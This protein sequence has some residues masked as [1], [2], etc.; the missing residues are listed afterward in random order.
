VVV[1]GSVRTRFLAAILVVV[2][3]SDAAA[4]WAMN[5]R[6]ATGA[7]REAENQARAQ[8][9]QV[10]ALFA[11]RAGTLAA[12][13]EAV[14]LYPAVIAA[15]AGGNNKPLLQWSGDVA[16]LQGTRVTVVDATGKVV[17]RGQAPQQVGD[18]LTGNL[19][20]L[21]IA[22]AGQKVS[23]VEPGDEL[24]LAI[25]GYA[26]TRQNGAVVGAVMIADPLDDQLA[27]KLIGAG[28]SI[29]ARVAAGGT[30]DAADSC[31]VLADASAA[32]CR[33]ALASPGGPPAATVSLT[34]PL[35]EVAQARDAAQRA[36][37]LT[38][39]VV[40]L[41]GIALAWLLARSL[42]RPLASLTAVAEDFGRGDYDRAVDVH[43]ADEIG[44]L[45]RE[46]EAMRQR[47]ASTTTALRNERDVLGAVLES[48]ED[49]IILVDWNGAPIVANG[50]WVELAGGNGLVALAEL[51]RVGGA[52]KTFA[53][54]TRAWL[55]DRDRVG[56]AD[57]EQFTPYRRF[58]CYSAP[59]RPREGA[60]LG[61]IIVLRDVTRESEAERM[62]GALVA[63]VSHELRSP[64]TAITGYT[65]TLLSGELWDDGTTRE[66]LDIVSQSARKL[67]SLV[68]NLLDA[69]KME[70]GVLSVEREPLRLERLARQVVAQRL[71]LVPGHKL[72]VDA[73]DDL[74]LVEADP[75]RVEQVIGNL[76]DNAIKYS[77]EGGSILVHVFSN[78]EGAVALSVSDQGIGIAPSHIE[79]LFQRFY[80]VDS[81]LART[82]KGVGLGLFICKGIVEAHG[83]R[84]EVTS[85]PG[86]GSTFTF[87]LP[88]LAAIDDAA[89]EVSDAP[90]KTG[91]GQ[92]LV[93]G[94]MG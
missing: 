80:R 79:Q 83:G 35:T 42:T 34:V 56:G 22:L 39:G 52:G 36:L 75:L 7:R 91:E 85:E 19:P 31:D 53:E 11:Q 58:R 45:A 76:V 70:A 48:T 73:E 38:G 69:A 4:A 57:F 61:R 59:V 27:Q 40:L 68:D 9:A 66:F 6:L 55:G 37:W 87:T 72:H 20:G 8:A 13:A 81:S 78:T 10:R 41:V 54:T 44:V 94:S 50:R 67:G 1:L 64:L 3:L 33:F 5:D 82:T 29:Q 77:P 86:V 74:P 88:R 93:S 2:I 71:P 62:R 65:D 30:A 92:R 60:A 89:A 18:N 46:F 84:I 12:E 43:G 51:S 26:P 17:A 32:T 21:R 49:G 24:G 15:I 25:R 63:T 28:S 16:A 14:S 23:G 47:I 90:P